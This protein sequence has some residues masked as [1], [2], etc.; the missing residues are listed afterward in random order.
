MG[1]RGLSTY[2]KNNVSEGVTIISLS[3]L[4]GKK[5]VID[6]SIYMYRFNENNEMIENFYSMILIFKQANIIPLFIFDGI[7]PKEKS[8]TIIERQ[9]ERNNA[10]SELASITNESS[11]ILHTLK[12]K[13]TR[14]SNRDRKSLKEL[15]E[16]CGVMYQ[17]ACGE[18]DS[19]CAKYVLNG[20]AWACL[21]DDMDLLVYSCPRV[22]RYFSLITKTAVL[23]NIDIIL[24]ELY[25]PFEIFQMICILSGTDYN[26]SIYTV[27]KLMSLYKTHPMQTIKIDNNQLREVNQI[28]EL[29]T[30]NVNDTYD[31]IKYNNCNAVKLRLFLEENNFIFI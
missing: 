28:K 23:Y 9:N 30:F 13:R 21:S 26:K 15:F 4:S 7:A 3:Q 31:I 11:G 20:E 5:V 29:F 17:Y 22:I 18:S 19:V 10:I 8:E 12:R 24:K 2:L 6:T 25:M 1:I 16:C 27:E 14:V